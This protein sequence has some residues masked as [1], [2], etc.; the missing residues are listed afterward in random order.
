MLKKNQKIIKSVLRPQKEQFCK[1]A[2]DTE[3]GFYYALDGFRIVRIEQAEFIGAEI[4]VF[5]IDTPKEKLPNYKRYIERANEVGYTELKIPYTPDQIDKWYSNNKK[6]K[7]R[8]PFALG[9]E[10][11]GSYRKRWFGINPKFLTD[12]MRTTGSQI[13]SVPDMGEQLVMQGNGYLWIICPVECKDDYPTNHHMT[14]IN[15]DNL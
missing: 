10:I 5:D 9:M 8:V 7:D 1:V 6:K 11:K 4:P 14:E 2:F 3:T 13:I 12:A 15:I